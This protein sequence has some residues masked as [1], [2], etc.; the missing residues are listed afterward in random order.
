MDS[1][2]NIPAQQIQSV[3]EKEYLIN[4]ERGGKTS[5]FNS[6][7]PEY[8]K[9]YMCKWRNNLTQEKKDTI[10]DTDTL[11][12]R[13]KRLNLTPI[14]KEMNRENDT[15]HKE[16]I[17][18]NL[19]QIKRDE[20][21][22]VDTNN[23]RISRFSLS[24]FVKEEIK[25]ID[26]SNRILARSEL[27]QTKK[28]EIKEND[29][30]RKRLKRLELLKIKTEDKMKKKGQNVHRRLK[31]NKMLK[32]YKNF[33]E[34]LEDWKLFLNEGQ[35]CIC[36]SCTRFVFFSNAIEFKQDKYDSIEQ[37][38]NEDWYFKIKNS[39]KS[40]WKRNGNYYICWTCNKALRSGNLPRF[41]RFNG[42]EIADTPEFFD[43]LC[44]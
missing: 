16:L 36:V 34:C 43:D 27:P 19:S 22:E 2:K 12:H 7:T 38:K 3:D 29:A 41:C 23:R 13:R 17:R 1:L 8:I 18:L 10:R 11:N 6:K 39:L 42:L 30:N 31:R 9:N 4:S 44:R 5:I 32:I 15:S 24:Q 25:R 14:E 20:I 35:S 26:T 33:E 40:K 37:L 21:R 28:D